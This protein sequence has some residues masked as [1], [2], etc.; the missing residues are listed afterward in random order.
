M[1]DTRKT[2]VVKFFSDERG[3]GFIK[4]DDGSGDVFVHAKD[5][6]RSGLQ[7]LQ[8]GDRISFSTQPSCNGKGPM[9]IDV[10]MAA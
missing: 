2:G 5:L 4:L 1:A 9:A 8:D 6:Q 10:R 7:T 3:Y